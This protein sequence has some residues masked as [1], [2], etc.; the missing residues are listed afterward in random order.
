MKDIRIIVQFGILRNIITTGHQMPDNWWYVYIPQDR[1]WH[2]VPNADVK[3]VSCD[4]CIHN[5]GIERWKKI[6]A[7]IEC[8][9]I[10]TNFSKLKII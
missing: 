10:N 9:G 6:S 2:F 7:C 8:Q 3:A 1:D 4:S 5:S